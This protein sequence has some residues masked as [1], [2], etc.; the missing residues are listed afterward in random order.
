MDKIN[1]ILTL[2]MILL[3]TI[4]LTSCTKK[5]NQESLNP[6]NTPDTVITPTS[7]NEIDKLLKKMTLEEKI[8][9]MII[10]SYR[11]ATVDST[12]NNTLNTVKPGG[13][14]L[15]KENITT[16]D[17]TLKFIKDV[18][19]T[20]TIPLFISI[21]E[22][23]GNVQRLPSLTDH[24]TSNIPYM[25]YVGK[26]ND[27]TNATKIGNVIAEELKVFGFNLDFAPDIDVWSNKN[28]TVIGRRSFGSD[29]TLVGNMGIS[30]GT[31]LLNNGIVPVYKHF[32]GHGNTATDSHYSL[33]VVT[34]TEAELMNSDLI[35]FTMAIENNAPI[36]M[37]GHLAVP[38]IT[39][40]DT[41]ASLSKILITDLLKTKMNY[42]G[43]VVTDAL[44]MGALTENYTS[45]QIYTM[46]V[47]AGVDILL[48]PS[49]SKECLEII[50]NAVL[51]GEISESRIDESVRKI[52]TL[53]YEKI[54]PTY[55]EYLDIDT[56][57]S[58]SHQQVIN[59]IPTE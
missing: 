23:G 40:D 12:L 54:E 17:A 39:K 52:L 7:E 4:C 53:K 37:V 5:N 26:T 16:Y 11:S 35:P 38:N 15:F 19:K 29:P 25:Y 13:I 31:S 1:K 14:I 56:L 48:M 24:E 3:M 36:I 43:L 47:N 32:P 9:Q 22:E 41:P 59:S 50:K 58:T 6:T 51:N 44:D 2:V 42:H 10:L 8:G 28:N 20:N 57:A 30:L 33:P 34:K 49:S 27:V 46:A 21:D 45:E 18:K 55:N